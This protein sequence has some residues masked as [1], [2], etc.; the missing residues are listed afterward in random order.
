MTCPGDGDSAW[1]EVPVV[2]DSRAA[3]CLDLQVLPKME[4]VRRNSPGF[5]NVHGARWDGSIGAGGSPPRLVLALSC[6]RQWQ[7]ACGANEPAVEWVGRA[8]FAASADRIS[9]QSASVP[10]VAAIAALSTNEVAA[11]PHR[12]FG[13]GDTLGKLYRELGGRNV[14]VPFAR[15]TFCR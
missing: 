15:L 11:M 4:I 1:V 3:S 2:A 5:A 14:D 8:Q 9:A 12:I 6:D 13:L 10:A 7:A